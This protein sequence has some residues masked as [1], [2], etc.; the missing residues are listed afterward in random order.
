MD[1][2]AIA[3]GAA[4]KPLRVQTET[5]GMMKIE[6]LCG[7]AGPLR[8]YNVRGVC[9][10]SDTAPGEV[11]VLTMPAGYYVVTLGTSSVSVVVK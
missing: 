8:I 5:P 6:S 11:V 10:Y 1:T 2:P 9:V 4:V 7:H 3:D